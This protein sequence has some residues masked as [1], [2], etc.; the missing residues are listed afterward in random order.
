MNMANVT[1]TYDTEN[2][3]PQNCG[4]CHYWKADSDNEGECHLNPPVVH[5]VMTP[6]KTLQGDAMQAQ[7]LS[8]FPRIKTDNYCGQFDYSDATLVDQV[9]GKP[10]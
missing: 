2:D 10:H 6:V 9:S 3:T 4:N 7:L 8:L 5:I 1:E